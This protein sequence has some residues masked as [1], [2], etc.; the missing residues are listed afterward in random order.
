MVE[1]GLAIEAHGS[2]AGVS[3]DEWDALFGQD[4][5][6]VSHAFLAALEDSHLND[7][8]YHLVT[9][10][11]GGRLV[12]ALSAFSITLDLALFAQGPVVRLV[13]A[14]RRLFPRFLMLPEME[15]GSPVSLGS[16]IAWA[17]GEDP[18]QVMPPMIRRLEDLARG[19]G[20]GLVVVR[21]FEAA[22]KPA[23]LAG[24]EWIPNLPDVSLAVRWR[25]FEEYLAAMRSE[26]RNRLRRRLRRSAEAGLVPR[27]E[28]RFGALAPR[29]RELWRQTFEEAR[30]YRREVLTEEWFVE[31]DR[32]LGDR[33]RALLLEQGGEVVAFAVVFQDDDTLRFLYAG[34]DRRLS[35]DGH[36]HALLALVVRHG[37]ECGCRTVE[38]GITTYPP[39]LDL[40]GRPVELW[41]GMRHL[42]PWLARV[43]PPLFKV[44]SPPVRPQPR[45]VFP[46]G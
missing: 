43:V 25:T 9:A 1:S 41:L 16:T 19:A 46:G 45:K 37:I 42:N 11:R 22:E 18:A 35:R 3:P 24:Y 36:Y 17:P 31:M 39:K 26:Y 5:L 21:D 6:P 28:P 20:I 34:L 12:A 4:R 14:V 38:L 23:W 32:R 10:R 44:L 27:V 30:E 8:R 29:L 2:V 40:G 15:C 33:S 7:C 13:H